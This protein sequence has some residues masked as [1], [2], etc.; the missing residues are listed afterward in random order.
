MLV[1]FKGFIMVS[2]KQCSLGLTDPKPTLRPPHQATEAVRCSRQPQEPAPTPKHPFG[3]AGTGQPSAQGSVVP[4]RIEPA[5]PPFP[6]PQTTLPT[7][8][9][10]ILSA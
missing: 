5:E 10:M 2:S 9:S 6:K 1:I 7:P 3:E 8:A 4:R